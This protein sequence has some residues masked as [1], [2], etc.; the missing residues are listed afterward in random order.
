M[1]TVLGIDIGTQSVKVVF[2]D[3]AA[4]DAVAVESASLDLHQ[5][6]DGVAEQQ[7]DWWI[8]ALQQALQKVG[9]DVRQSAAAIGVSGI[10]VYQVSVGKRISGLFGSVS[11]IARNRGVEASHIGKFRRR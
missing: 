3:V 10:P 7:A 4:C 5:T 2:Y 6:E 9:K 11:G 8:H 1:S